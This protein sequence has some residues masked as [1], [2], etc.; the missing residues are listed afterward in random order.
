MR[1]Q[2]AVRCGFLAFGLLL[3]GCSMGG[4]TAT[5]PTTPPV[6]PPPPSGTPTDVLTY[7]NDIARTGQNL[8]ETTL[9]TSNV[10][11]ATF[12][13]IGFYAAD[14]RVDAQPLYASNVTISGKGHNILIVPTEHDSV[15]GF[16]ADTGVVL[17]QASM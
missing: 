7:H 17:W 11:S 2:I 6:N 13:K 8:Q 15:Y 10:N 4:N 14:G 16:D 9:T 12:G 3:T 5:V 1:L